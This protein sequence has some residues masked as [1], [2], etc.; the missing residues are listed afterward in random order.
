MNKHYK[1]DYYYRFM[2]FFWRLTG[3]INRKIGKRMTNYIIKKYCGEN[4]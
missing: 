2:R 3:S 1:D 4:E